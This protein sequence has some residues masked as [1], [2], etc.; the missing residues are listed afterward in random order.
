MED[1]ISPRPKLNIYF[2][3]QDK[4]ERGKEREEK[5]E[6]RGREN[7]AECNA[8]AFKSIDNTN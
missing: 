4:I 5:D 8:P 7:E 2:L 3:G 6:E 1:K